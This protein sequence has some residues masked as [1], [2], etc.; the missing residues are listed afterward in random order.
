MTAVKDSMVFFK[1]SL[2]ATYYIYDILHIATFVP[3]TEVQVAMTG[4][5]TD[6]TVQ[7]EWTEQLNGH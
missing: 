2:I 1:A 4:P 5:V 7:T 6:Q 3:G